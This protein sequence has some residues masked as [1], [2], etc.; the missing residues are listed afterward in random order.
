MLPFPLYSCLENQPFIPAL[1][2]KKK[3]VISLW[4]GPS[5][6]RNYFLPPFATYRLDLSHLETLQWLLT[7]GKCRVI[8]C[9]NK[10]MLL[11]LYLA[12]SYTTL[13]T[14]VQTFSPVLIIWVYLYI[15]DAGTFATGSSFCHTHPCLFCAS[16]CRSGCGRYLLVCTKG[17][18]PQTTLISSISSLS[19]HIFIEGTIVWDLHQCLHMWLWP[20]G[21]IMLLRCSDLGEKIKNKYNR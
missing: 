1:W 20:K 9:F 4:C 11:V 18:V 3:S 6:P 5:S 8:H 17:S 15:L 19:Q 10:L 12:A 16:C 14:S 13:V 7:P 21:K 2:N